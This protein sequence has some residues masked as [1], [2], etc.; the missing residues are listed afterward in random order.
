MELNRR[1]LI[2]L[3][4]VGGATAVVSVN[5]PALGL[6]VAIKAPPTLLSG[7]VTLPGGFTVPPGAVWAFDPE[8]STTVVVRANVVVEGKLEMRPARPDVVHTLRF[9]GIDESRFVGGSVSVPLPSDVGLWVIGAGI[10]DAQGSPKA[11]WNRTGD[12]STWMTS[13]ELVVAPNAPGDFGG[14]RPFTKGDEVPVQTGPG[15]VVYGTEVA[16][17]TRNV[18]IEG[19]RDGRAH[20]MFLGCRRPQTLRYVAVS[21][22]APQ[23]PTGGIYRLNG[24]TLPEF[25]GVLGR[26]GLHFHDCGDGSRGSLIEGVV[27]RKAGGRAF[28]P[29]SSHGMTFRDCLATDVRSSGF[30]WD[31]GAETDDILFDR[32]AVL[33][34][35]NNPGDTG[36]GLAGFSLGLG[37]NNVVRR[38]VVAG[39]LNNKVNSGGYHWPSSANKG[40]N[41]WTWEDNVAH[42]NKDGGIGVWQND[43]NPHVV[44]GYVGYN[45]GIGISHGAYANN[46]TY[47]DS[48]TFGNGTELVQHALGGITFERMVFDGDL[49]LTKHSLPSVRT[50]TYIDCRVTGT[51]RVAESEEGGVIRF[52]SSTPATDLELARF[53][54]LS[55]L[56]DITVRNSDGRSYRVRP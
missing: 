55:V 46:Y 3:G 38:S 47:R 49:L 26:Y 37:G 7:V 54:R 9:E 17:L 11:G 56:S 44:S 21:Y 5:R 39:V 50:T 6:G 22:M 8:V 14:V 32:C 15:G 2:K 27:I 29:H 18:A 52:E 40:R 13:D 43:G 4:L 1:G 48:V 25:E 10:L 20:I 41:V 53:S 28:V 19:T 23:Q 16:N 12:D 36:L 24:A 31:D 42:N 35:P 45:N 30:W 51:I 33:G 34:V